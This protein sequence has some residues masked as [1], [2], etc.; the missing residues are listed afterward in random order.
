M[1]KIDQITEKLSELLDDAD[2]WVMDGETTVAYKPCSLFVGFGKN[3]IRVFRGSDSI[4]LPQEAVA[5]LMPKIEAVAK[6][7][8]FTERLCDDIL[9]KMNNES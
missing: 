3:Y 8:E 2:N 7:S 1:T 4:D 6:P 9:A 5:K